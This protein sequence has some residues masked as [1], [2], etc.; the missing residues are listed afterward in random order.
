M[1]WIWKSLS[2]S[3]RLVSS[4]IAWCRRNRLAKRS[5]GCNAGNAPSAVRAARKIVEDLG[6]K[7]FSIKKQNKVLYHAFGSFASPQLI[8]LMAAMERV[9]LAAGIRRQDIKT[10]MLPLLQQTLRNYLDKTAAAAF[11]GPLVRGDVATVRRHLAELKAL[12]EVRELYIALAK[13]SLRNLP[14][15]NRSLLRRELLAD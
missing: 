11:S 1:T 2:G 7:G 4:S 5:P 14:V 10:V 13:A 9:G 8:A 3:S 6:G 15:K 12:P